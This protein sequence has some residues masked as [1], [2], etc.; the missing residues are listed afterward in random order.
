VVAFPGTPSEAARFVSYGRGPVQ[1]RTLRSP[2]DAPA[3]V[4]DAALIS[5]LLYEDEL[6]ALGGGAATFEAAAGPCLAV[7]AL[8]ESAVRWDHVRWQV[9]FRAE[10]AL[11]TPA[12]GSVGRLRAALAP[13]EVLVVL[14]AAVLPSAEGPAV[15]VVSPDRRGVTRR[16]VELGRAFSGYTS[17]LS[18][19]AEGELV[20]VMNAFFLDA[21]R[22]LARN[23][24]TEAVPVR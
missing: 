24:P 11:A 19:M 7:I 8:A 1:R 13:R 3:W 14:S 17:V 21:E 2:L 15:L 20:I 18:G 23:A 9:K 10:D 5:A 22:R 16:P 12:A 6:R 4:D